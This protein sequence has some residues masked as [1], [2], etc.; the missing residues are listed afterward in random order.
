MKATRKA[1]AA[2]FGS[3][4]QGLSHAG[5]GR[6]EGDD[7]DQGEEDVRHGGDEEEDCPLGVLGHFFLLESM[8][9]VE[10]TRRIA[11]TTTLESATLKVGQRS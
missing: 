4:A 5:P 7:Q 8:N 9:I 11:Q 6:Q 3:D 2:V 1:G 10:T